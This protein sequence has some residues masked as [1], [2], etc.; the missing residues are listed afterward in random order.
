LKKTDAFVIY[1]IRILNRASLESAFGRSNYL[2]LLNLYAERINI[3]LKD[4]S[5]ISEISRDTLVIVSPPPKNFC[6]D[7]ISLLLNQGRDLGENKSRTY[8]NINIGIASYPD[9]GKTANEL[10]RVARLALDHVLYTPGITHEFYNKSL[11]DTVLEELKVGAHLKTR[12]DNDEFELHYPPQYNASKSQVVEIEA[13]L[14]WHSPDLGD[15]SP[16]IFINVAE[17]SGLL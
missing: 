16:E 7:E 15:V 17:E 13:L 11:K 6:S 2:K 14:R 1:Y 10:L 8:F 4:L 3:Y 5:F 9:N 12:L